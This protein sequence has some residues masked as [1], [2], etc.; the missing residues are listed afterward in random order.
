MIHDTHMS[1]FINP[2]LFHFSTGTITYI[3]GQKAGTI[4]A[5]RAA[6]NQTTLITIP[7]CIPSNASAM[8]G[9]YLKSIELDYE[10]LVAEPTSLTWTI[11]KVTRG[12]DGADATITTPAFTSDLSAATAK[13]V[14]EHKIVHTITTPFWID[15]DEYVLLE[16][17]LEAGGGGNTADFI[18]AVVNYTFRC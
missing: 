17:A 14:D 8:K 6:A 4:V 11:N 13:A 15:N 7:I 16:L 9:S 12:A 10:I 2:Q 5:H 18:S 1:Q 3:A